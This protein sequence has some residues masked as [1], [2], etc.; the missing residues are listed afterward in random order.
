MVF[1]PSSHV[2]PPALLGGPLDGGE[3]A[4]SST[5]HPVNPVVP[6]YFSRASQAILLHLGMMMIPITV[7]QVTGPII[8]I[9]ALIARMMLTVKMR[10]SLMS[11]VKLMNF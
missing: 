10:M 7:T 3:P 5:D 1:V 2:G 9:S 11:L 4:S 8:M 6:F